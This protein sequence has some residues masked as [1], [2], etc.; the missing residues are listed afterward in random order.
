MK[1]A[2][3]FQVGTL[4]TLGPDALDNPL[5]WVGLFSF[6][7]CW[8]FPHFNGT[9]NTFFILLEPEVWARGSRVT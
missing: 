2:S 3:W 6:L 5:A 1:L 8:Q 7:F 4:R 9:S